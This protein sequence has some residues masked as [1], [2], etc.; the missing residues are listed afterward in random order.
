MSLSEN[1][2]KASKKAMTDG[3]IYLDATKDY[4][5]LRMLK[6]LSLFFSKF[7]KILIFGILSLFTFILALI[8]Y[9][10]ELKRILGSLY[11]AFL[12]CAGTLFLIGLLL[13]IFRKPLIDRAAI[14]FT[15]K[16]FFEATN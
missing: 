11:L 8:A 3:E 13:Y 14:A 1:I 4:V 5:E 2:Y 6:T 10:I 9:V 7:L 15:S 16:T 12:T